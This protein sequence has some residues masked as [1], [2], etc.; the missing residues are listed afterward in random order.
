[1]IIRRDILIALGLNLT[2]SDHA[3]ESYYVTFKASTETTV[4]LGTYEF[5]D[6]NR[7]KITPEESFIN[8]YIEYIYELEQVWIATK[9]LCVILYAK[10]EKEY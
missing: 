7:G 10:Y 8:S 1:M 9:R 5:K 2:L 6:L 3:I 4:D